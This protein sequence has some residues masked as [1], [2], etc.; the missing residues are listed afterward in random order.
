MS[1]DVFCLVV[2]PKVDC[3]LGTICSASVMDP[4]LCNFLMLSAG[5]MYI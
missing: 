5:T 1:Y 2:P 4:V 3:I